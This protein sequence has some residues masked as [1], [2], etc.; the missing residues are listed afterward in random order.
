MDSLDALI[1]RSQQADE[2][3]RQALHGDSG[4]LAQLYRHHLDDIYRYVYM[5]VGTQADAE[6]L[7]SETFLRMVENLRQYRERGKFRSWLLGIARYVVNDFWRIHY[8]IGEEPLGE[9]EMKW[10]ADPFSSDDPNNELEGQKNLVFLMREWL[11]RLPDHYRRVL[12]LRFLEGR[13]LRETAQAMNCTE[14]TVKVRQHR[15]L[16]KLAQAITEAEEDN[17]AEVITAEVDE[18]E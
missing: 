18:N 14:T 10:A 2:L 9:L 17:F 6:D 13:S 11:A 3:V 7:T 4:A 1:D 8:R 5:R 16:K 15:A 12:E